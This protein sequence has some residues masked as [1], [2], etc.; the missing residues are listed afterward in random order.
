MTNKNDYEALKL[1][2]QICFPL[3]ACSRNV[4]NLYTLFFKPIGLTYTQYIVLLVLW[5]KDGISVGELGK[6]LYLDNGTLTPLLK[7]MQEK[8]YL[9]RQRSHDDERIVLVSLTE[10]GSKLRDKVED[11]PARINDSLSLTSE[12]METLYGLLYKVID[13]LEEK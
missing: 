7:K 2:K 4:V 5:E 10:E 11:I 3:Y 13:G 12:E 1:D 9:I 6:K 8:G